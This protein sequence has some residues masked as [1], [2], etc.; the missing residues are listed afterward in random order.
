VGYSKHPP[1]PIP[2][3]VMGRLIGYSPPIPHLFHTKKQQ[4]NN[5]AISQPLAPKQQR[6][7][8]KGWAPEVGEL[9]G[10][11][12]E[13]YGKWI[14]TT[15]RLSSGIPASRSTT[16]LPYRSDSARTH[17]PAFQFKRNVYPSITAS[18]YFK[19]ATPMTTNSPILPTG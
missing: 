15:F 16:P 9:L 17:G 18:T 13:M 4:R 8:A 6:L 3:D 19:Q 5:P 11:L 14:H 7:G 12:Q 1:Q 2:H 10:M